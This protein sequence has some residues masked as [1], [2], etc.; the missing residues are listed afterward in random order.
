MPGRRSTAPNLNHLRERIDAW[1]LDRRGRSMPAELWEAAA[2]AAAELGVSRVATALRLG[3]APL[4]ARVATA[5]EPGQ[6]RDPATF[7]ELSGAQLLTPVA[8]DAV[9]IELARGEARLTITAPVN[10]PVDLAALVS[11]FL[12]G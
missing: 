1:R 3:Y 10:A 2:S 6:R 8:G 4:K 7:V 11:A 9:R 12:R 5:D